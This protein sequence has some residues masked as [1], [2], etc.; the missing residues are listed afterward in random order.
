MGDE[1]NVETGRLVK[2]EYATGAGADESA[3]IGLAKQV[4]LKLCKP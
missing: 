4:V 1:N 3:L 2:S